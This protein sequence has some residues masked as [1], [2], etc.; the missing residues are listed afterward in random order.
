MCFRKPL[1]VI[2]QSLYFVNAL[3]FMHQEYKL[4]NFSLNLVPELDFMSD[5]TRYIS[6]G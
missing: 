3:K 4:M 5:F 2:R 1:L 6:K